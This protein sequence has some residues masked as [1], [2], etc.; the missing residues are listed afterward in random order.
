MR[1][2]Q[3]LVDRYRSTYEGER[4]AALVLSAMVLVI[5]M[6]MAAFAVDYGWIAYNRLEVRKAAEAAA[7]A[8]VVHMP[9]PDSVAF[10]AGA[11]SYDVA[12]DV[13]ERNGYISGVG[14]VTVT[15]QED[16]K[17]GV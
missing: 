2:H 10:G 4:G 17:S 5:L 13:A 12:I 9:F 11:E 16:R 1:L 15:P 6:G 7:L 14:G 8:G 3:R